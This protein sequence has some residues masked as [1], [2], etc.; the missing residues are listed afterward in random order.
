MV[1]TEEKGL[2]AGFHLLAE[3]ALVG[4]ASASQGDEVRGPAARGAVVF[5]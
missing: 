3:V 2:A 1:R 4:A 5:R